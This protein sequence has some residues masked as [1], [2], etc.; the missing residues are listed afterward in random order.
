[1][2]ASKKIVIFFFLIFLSS[3]MSCA[4]PAVRN[5]ISDIVIE[6]HA[7]YHQR[8]HTESGFR[9]L[10]P[11]P[12]RDVGKAV[13]LIMNK[14][15]FGEKRTS[16]VPVRKVTAEEFRSSYEKTMREGSGIRYWW[17][18]HST[19]VIHTSS[20]VFLTDPV[21]SDRVSPV[22]F[23]GPERLIPLPAQIS[24][25]G[26]VDYVLISHNHY[27]HLDEASV[28]ELWKLYNPLFFVPARVGSL[29]RSWG[30]AK[31]IELDWW[32][33]VT[34]KGIKFH[35]TPA[36][37]FS[38]RGLF[39]RNETLWASWYV[40]DLPSSFRFYFAG[41]TGYSSHFKEI[42]ETIGSPDLAMIPIGAYEPRWFMSEVHV[43]PDQAVQAFVDLQAAKMLPIHWGTFPLA[44]EGMMEPPKRMFE[45]ASR[46]GLAADRFDSVEAG[47]PV[48]FY[49]A[50]RR[51]DERM[52]LGA[53]P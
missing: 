41:D 40:E 30:V 48:E 33:Y 4:L 13:F 46:S 34:V 45:A 47:E 7:N 27:D 3:A 53:L 5:D 15:L 52:P 31:V 44:E 14:I 23:A 1:M 24:D 28:K 8:H 18:G 22:S 20:G 35:C 21:F 43:D 32:E 26:R 51:Y 29:L 17:L 6:K 19:V 9:N 2:T 49:R 11:P 37:H 10:D 25:L 38:A 42:R 39:D 12:E 36:R 16:E 50:G